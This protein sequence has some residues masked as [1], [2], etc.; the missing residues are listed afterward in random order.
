MI[1]IQI[2]NILV[3]TKFTGIVRTEYEVCLH[4]YELYEQ[5]ENIGFSA[6]DET[7]G[8][9]AISPQII[10]SQLDA[11]KFGTEPQIVSIPRLPFKKRFKRSVSKRINRLKE[12]F[13]VLVY[14]FKSGDTIICVGQRLHSN[15][16][17]SFEII[18]QKVDLTLMFYCH[19]VLP[20][21]NAQFFETNHSLSFNKYMEQVLKVVDFF[22]CNSEFTKQELIKYYQRFDLKPVAMQVVTLGCDLYRQY[23]PDYQTKLSINLNEKFLLF[24]STIEVRK[25]HQLIYDMYVDLI[26]AGIDNLPKIYFVGRRGW[27]VEQFLEAIN[28]DK[29]IQDKLIILENVCDDD[30]ILLYKH[31]WF[32]LYPSYVEGYGLPVAE[33]LS[34]GKYCLSSNGGSLPEAGGKFIDYISPYDLTAWKDKFLFLIS[35]PE[36]IAQKEQHIK[37]NHKAVGWQQTATK[38]VN[39]AKEQSLGSSHST[40][41][42]PTDQPNKTDEKITPQNLVTQ[43][44]KTTIAFV[45]EFFPAGGAEMVTSMLAVELSKLNYEVIVFAYEIKEDLLTQEDKKYLNIIKVDKSDLFEVTTYRNNLVKNIHHLNIDIV[46]FVGSIA[47]NIQGITKSLKC[48]TVFA[49]HGSPL[50]EIVDLKEE[51]LRKNPTLINSDELKSVLDEETQKT[52]RKYQEIYYACDAFSVL[53]EQYKYDI[54]KTLPKHAAD[55]LVVIANAIAPKKID[56]NLNKKKQLLYVGRM[57]YA[58]KR[59]DRLIEIW[60]N[61]YQKF[62]DWEFLLVGD[63]IERKNL[64]KQATENKLERIYFCGKTN[65]PY[66]YYNNASILC[67]SSQF[68]G[69]GLVLAE[70][71]QAGVIPVAFNCSA[72]VESI[73]SPNWENGVLIDNFSMLEY[74]NAL[75]K[76]MSDDILR[77]QMQHN[78][79]NKSK[80]YDIA[81]V[82]KIWHQLFMKLLAG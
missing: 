26:E 17:I 55:K 35:N 65:K 79:L 14:P 64:E 20:A 48:K 61:I 43:K 56:Y 4:A 44:Q 50:W 78:I 77:Q 58:D 25:N 67:L 75:C 51:V 42:Q 12:K 49:F 18:K 72:G 15:D 19:D 59:I 57:S 81:K 24:V 37:D 31:C 16:L 53:C 68:E 45:H 6:Y 41:P 63:G 8:F 7:K 34:F 22:Y 80:E 38:I 11:L 52:L 62:P 33:S 29:R 13:G 69:F 54:Q 73:L 66:E 27:K 39:Y 76:L 46:I 5:G 60:K 36:Y 28:T 3:D 2:C 1:W 21:S 40:E 32:T 9:Y 30:L 70:A 47:F 71:Q 23:S 74:E 10:K 82:A